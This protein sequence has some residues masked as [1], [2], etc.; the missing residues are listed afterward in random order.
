MRLFNVKLL[1]VSLALLGALL[2]GCGSSSGVSVGQTLFMSD[3]SQFGTVVEV[4]DSHQFENG[5][6]EPGV[7]VDYS[8]RI[9]GVQAWLPTRSAEKMLQ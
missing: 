7:L 2:T 5:I 6:S 4:S 8:P 1:A 3:G 9:N